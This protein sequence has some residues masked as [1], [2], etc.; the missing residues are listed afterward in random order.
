MNRRQFALRTG[1]APFALAMGSAAFAQAA[2]P[3]EGRDYTR[4]ATALPMP[5][6]GK[7]EV[8]EFFM[9][10]C[11]HC[12]AFEPALDAWSKKL[13]PDVVLQRVPVFFGRADQEMHRKIFY[14]L[15]AIGKLEEMHRK[16]FAAIHVQHQYLDQIGDVKKFMTANGVDA[17]KFEA[18]AKSFSVIG[19]L[20][21][22]QQL[23]DAHHI[24]GVPTLGV[25]GRYLTSGSM[26]GSNERALQ[27]VEYLVAKI[28]KG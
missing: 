25:H 10:S 22:A 16:V 17:D 4:L 5:A 12:N 21:Q 18:A 27:V 26:T 7:I 1:A 20:R 15:E 14:G 2:A 9:Y 8:V 24:D 3:V 28:R 6:N 11:P 23:M 19:K 13:P